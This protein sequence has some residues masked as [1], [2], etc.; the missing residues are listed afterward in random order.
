MRRRLSYANVAAT[1]ALVFSMS[2][3]ALAAKHYLIN[4]TKEINPKVLGKLKGNIGPR[5][6]S[7]QQ[8]PQGL[9]G[10]QGPQGPP[11]ALGPQGAPGA[12]GEPGQ[13]ALTPLQS[14]QTERGVI[15]MAT[16]V[17]DMESEAS[18]FDSAFASLPIPAP[19]AIDNFHV[20]VA[21]VTDKG[22]CT[23][24]YASPTAPGGYVCIY[25]N[26]I[27]QA[28]GLVG[29]VP[30]AESTPYGFGLAWDAAGKGTSSDVQGDWAYTAP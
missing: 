3:G 21:G 4:S 6:L 27:I 16:V 14:G 18:A 9:Q 15:G 25:V 24:S 8:G 20:F 23:G 2:G 28:T 1:L 7:G 5:G 11:G 17:G 10:A 26:F 22:A 30:G 19:V 29:F 12:K 13:S